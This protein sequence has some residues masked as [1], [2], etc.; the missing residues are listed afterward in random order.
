MVMQ[1]QKLMKE[2]TLL[3]FY[4]FQERPKSTHCGEAPT[5]LVS[6]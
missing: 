1:T 3:K 4:I 2:E 6:S 5:V